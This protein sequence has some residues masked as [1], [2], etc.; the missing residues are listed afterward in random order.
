M[1]NVLIVARKEFADIIKNP[2]VIVAILSYVILILSYIYIDY[3]YQD[4]IARRMIF[5]RMY[6]LYVGFGCIV[7]V[8]IGFASIASEYGGTLNT[9]IT[10]PLY[11]DTI[12]NGKMIACI[13]SILCINVVS[14]LFMVS[15]MI[16]LF[17][18]TASQTLL[19]SFDQIS[20]LFLLSL[21]YSSIFLLL[22][23][24][25]CILVNSRSMAF[26]ACIL[27]LILLTESLPG[28]HI[29]GTVSKIFYLLNPA[30]EGLVYQ[31]IT[32]MMPDVIM[33]NLYAIGIPDLSS[34]FAGSGSI[35]DFRFLLL[36]IY[37]VILLFSCY[38][39]FIR[40]DIP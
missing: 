24:L 39:S 18:E 32:D 20:V 36:F 19:S 1:N 15:L 40:R 29:A 23:M 16:A 12:I 17:G 5:H 8:F 37:P 3:N 2:A 4:E 22:S 33:Y 13:C 14:F 28:V 25:I 31:T 38:I 34:L 6:S 9:L 11:R 26:M 21:L 27:M 7:P 35:H 30:Y 10:K